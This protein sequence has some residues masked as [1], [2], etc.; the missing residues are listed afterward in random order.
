M[1][2]EQ[3]NELVFCNLHLRFKEGMSRE[4]KERIRI[5]LENGGPIEVSIFNEEILPG[6]DYA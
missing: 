5:K 2:P 1:H 6:M 4:T 3:G